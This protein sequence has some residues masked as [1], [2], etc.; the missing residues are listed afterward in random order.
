MSNIY[1]T[2]V[3]IMCNIAQH[4]EIL[5][6]NAVEDHMKESAEFATDQENLQTTL[7]DIHRDQT[8]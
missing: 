2:Q 5:K 1:E 6:S 3:K 8:R 4:L 7:F